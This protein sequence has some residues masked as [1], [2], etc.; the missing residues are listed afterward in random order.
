M[1]HRKAFHYKAC[2]H[3]IQE[4]RSVIRMNDTRAYEFADE[5]D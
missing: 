2:D 5:I 3:V 1:R 4:L